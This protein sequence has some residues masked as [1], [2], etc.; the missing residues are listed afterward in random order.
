[1]WKI[2]YWT[3]RCCWK[4]TDLEERIKQ[5]D[6]KI[7]QNHSFKIELEND[8]ESLTNELKEVESRLK[9]IEIALSQETA[10]EKLIEQG[11]IEVNKE[12]RIKV[13]KKLATTYASE[14]KNIDNQIEVLKNRI[15]EK[16]TKFERNWKR[17]FK[18]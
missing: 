3:W 13:F 9:S 16:C 17:N 10:R 15:Q 14:I 4:Q 6:S 8:I 1:M 11:E 5:T 18:T 7:G 2:K 12:E